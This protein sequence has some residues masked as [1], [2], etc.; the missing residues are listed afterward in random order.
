VSPDRLKKLL[1]GC[2]VTVP[3]PFEDADGLPVNEL[4]LRTYVR[5]LLD[6]GLTADYATLLAG[7]AAG[8]FS[9]MS[10]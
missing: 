7:G 5:F 10:F 3:T 2:Y 1:E 8:D 6:A 4:A 9:T